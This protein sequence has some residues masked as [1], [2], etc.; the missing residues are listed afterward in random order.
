MKK[1]EKI[2]A[3]KK[4]LILE[5]AKKEF[6]E[7]GFDGARME[8]IAK[9]AGVNKALLHYHYTNKENLYRE[10]LDQHSLFDAKL[11][12]RIAEYSNTVRMS[13]PEKLYIAIYLLININID[14]MDDDFRKILSREMTEERE[15]FRKI[16]QSYIIP[17]HEA[18]AGI[19]IE[20]IESGHFASK[21][22]LFVVISLNTFIMTLIN[23]RNLIKGSSW[24]NRIYGKRYRETLFDFMVDHTFRALCPPGRELNIPKMPEGTFDTIKKFVDDVKKEQ[25][26]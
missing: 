21:N 15:H 12:N 13:P 17:R 24:Y 20:G 26:E 19:I 11:I 18:F 6:A 5:A 7:K 1:N 10:V 4:S 23:T 9:R 2:Q 3:N 14:T 25:T 22:P 8:S 16:V